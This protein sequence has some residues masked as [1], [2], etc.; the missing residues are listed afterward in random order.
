MRFERGCW[1]PENQPDSAVRR[2]R[3]AGQA[4]AEIFTITR[5]LVAQPWRARSRL[6]CRVLR[7]TD[8]GAEEWRGGTRPRG[9]NYANPASRPLTDRMRI[10][11]RHIEPERPDL[12]SVPDRCR[13]AF[14]EP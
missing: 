2:C 12:A 1:T 14:L 11:A 8:S 9:G 4:L 7:P 6:Q 13:H 3:R 5:R 10:K